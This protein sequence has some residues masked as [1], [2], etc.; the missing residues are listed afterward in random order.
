VLL[1]PV[2]LIARAV[3]SGREMWSILS[4]DSVVAALR[5]TVLLCGSVTATCVI[6]AVPLAWLTART[7]LP[8]RSFWS[9]V[10]V[11][12]LSIP[13]FIGGFITVS[14]LGPGGMFQDL[15]EPFG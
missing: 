9:V 1:P 5:R 2:Y 10:L 3:G 14:A 15:L 6:L 13:S 8:L 12:P 4:D 7:D 11:L